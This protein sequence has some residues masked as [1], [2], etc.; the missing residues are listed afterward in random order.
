[1]NKVLLCLT[2]TLLLPAWIAGQEIEPPA[3]EDTAKAKPSPVQLVVN[4]AADFGLTLVDAADGLALDWKLAGTSPDLSL[5]QDAWLAQGGKKDPQKRGLFLGWQIDTS[6]KT[7]TPAG[8]DPYLGLAEF[9]GV[10]TLGLRSQDQAKAGWSQDLYGQLLVL[11]LKDQDPWYLPGGANPNAFWT[12]LIPQV[13][14]SAL[15]RDKGPTGQWSYA[16]GLSGGV[17]AE[18]AW[19]RFFPG[20]YGAWL[21]LKAEGDLSREANADWFWLYRFNAEGSSGILAPWLKAKTGLGWRIE[22]EKTVRV[23]VWAA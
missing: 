3:A 2:L 22:A 15:Y 20:I 7:Q 6:L 21:E 11:S 23:D 16:N 12:R 17:D 19:N 1:M 13:G 4:T 8:L 5:A 18:N 14:W 9:S 10:L